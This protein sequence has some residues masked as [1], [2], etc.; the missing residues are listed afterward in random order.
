VVLDNISH[1]GIDAHVYLS[2]GSNEKNLGDVSCINSWQDIFFS[3]YNLEFCLTMVPHSSLFT[4]RYLDVDNSP[5]FHIVKPADAF[6]YP[7]EL[8][9]D[10]VCI[11]VFLIG[12]QPAEKL[13]SLCLFGNKLPNCYFINFN[14]SNFKNEQTWV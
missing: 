9:L 1:D 10:D 3:V 7:I 8:Q 12:L 13:A 5:L 2:L 14:K 4:V 11:N 6:I